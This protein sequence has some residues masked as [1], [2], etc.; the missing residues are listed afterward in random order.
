M[1]RL[2]KNE[3]VKVIVAA[4]LIIALIAAPLVY[5]GGQQARV[6][7]VLSGLNIDLGDILLNRDARNAAH[8]TTVDSPID[9]RWTFDAESVKALDITWNVGSVSVKRGTGDQVAVHERVGIGTYDMD[10]TK[11]TVKLDEGTGTLSV[12]DGLPKG[13]DSTYDLP[14]ME[15]EIELPQ[16]VAL[17]SVSLK[18]T[19]ASLSLADLACDNLD[20]ATVS[21]DVTVSTLDAGGVSVATISGAIALDGSAMGSL[22]ISTVSGDIKVS[23]TGSLPPSL[24]AS[25]TSGAILL[26]LPD[27]AGFTLTSDRVSGSFSSALGETAENG[28]SARVV[29]GD[30]AAKITADSVSGSVTVR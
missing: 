30:G 15:L 24:D 25:T 4:A 5:L 26:D 19:V 11:A 22:D 1:V 21:S 12:D 8:R 28:P 2:Q 29:A 20:V 6:S 14:P 18:S 27:D 13:I 9:E 17:G 16:G 23:P 10:P 3:K 7:N